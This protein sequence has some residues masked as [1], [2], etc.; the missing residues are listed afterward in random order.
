[1]GRISLITAIIAAL[2]VSNAAG[3][4]FLYSREKR[5]SFPFYYVIGDETLQPVNKDFFDLSVQDATG[6]MFDFSQL[7][8]FK[9]TLIFNSASL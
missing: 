3:S 1:M 2:V 4:V 6:K 5:Q 9:A 8:K 7:R